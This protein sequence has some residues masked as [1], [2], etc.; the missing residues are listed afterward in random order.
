MIAFKCCLSACGLAVTWGVLSPAFAETRSELSMTFEGPELLHDQP[1]PDAP[2]FAHVSSRNPETESRVQLA[3]GAQAPGYVRG[4]STAALLRVEAP[5]SFEN[6][7]LTVRDVSSSLALALQ[8]ADA[9]SLELR[10]FPFDTDYV[11]LGYLH[12]LDW[13]GTNRAQRQSAF[14]TQSGGAPGA[15]IRFMT[16]PARLFLGLKWANVSR[17]GAGDERLLGIMLGGTFA[18]WSAL[19]LDA[20]FGYFERPELSSGRGGSEPLEGASL[21]VTWHRGID[22]PELTPEPFR[23]PPLHDAAVGLGSEPRPGAAL[24]LEGVLLV[25]R[26][27]L[28]A[29]PRTTLLAKAPAAGL[30]G[31]LRQGVLAA[32]GALTWRS[33]RFVLR[34]ERPVLDAPSPKA[35]ERAELAGW[36]GASLT[37]FPPALV[38]SAEIGVRLP[39]ALETP[40]P[41][42]G[43]AQSYVAGSGGLSG[44]PLG[45]GRLPIL[46]ARLALRFQASADL[47]L[48]VLGDYC[49]DPNRTRFSDTATGG[50]AFAP[51]DS[52]TARAA[53]QARF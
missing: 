6:K 20:G 16:E 9:T 21:R 52:L 50:R 11:R 49:R 34:N 25:E 10:V 12:A 41:L 31:S 48:A 19:K 38:P 2:S 33:L 7:A 40:S 8:L 1:H 29:T 36:L 28:L 4:T 3:L 44:L 5:L 22:E 53:V 51:P 46:D 24:A 23:P 18:A 47:A 42:A 30:Y 32:H 26:Q 15:F 27:Q 35:R 17:A 37:L 13:G 14:L 43:W 39:A 45:S